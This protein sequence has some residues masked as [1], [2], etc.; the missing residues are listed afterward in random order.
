M[1]G[2]AWSRRLLAAVMLAVAP[3][4]G[5][6]DTTA[7]VHT[8]ND[9]GFRVRSSQGVIDLTNDT[10]APVYTHVI[11]RVASET[12][13]WVPCDDP[14]TCAPLAPGASR[15]VEFPEAMEEGF[16]EVEAIVSWWHLVPDGEGGFT[17]DSVRS[18][19]IQR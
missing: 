19:V 7:P 14:A 10:S 2:R 5:C 3:L 12:T 9:H 1:Q 17:P 8:V 13:E 4:S 6:E 15:R 11:G 18:L 16:S